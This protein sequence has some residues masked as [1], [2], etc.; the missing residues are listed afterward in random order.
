MAKS[1]TTQTPGQPDQTAQTPD[2]P[3]TTQEQSKV[4]VVTPQVKPKA[5]SPKVKETREINGIKVETY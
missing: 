3:Q 1:Q 2:T 5:D 4:R